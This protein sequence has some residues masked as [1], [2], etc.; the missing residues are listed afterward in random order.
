M[1]RKSNKR[2]EAPRR[3][4]VRYGRTGVMEAVVEA[5]SADEVSDE[6]LPGVFAGIPAGMIGTH[7][8]DVRDDEFTWDV[9]EAGEGDGAPTART[10]T[11]LG[12]GR[13]GKGSCLRDDTW[14]EHVEAESADGAAEE[15]LRRR[16]A[17]SGMDDSA[18]LAVFGGRHEDALADIA[19]RPARRGPDGRTAGRKGTR[20]ATCSA[21]GKPCDAR[22]AHLHR[23]KL[24]GDE[25][26]WDERLRASE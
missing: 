17:K 7:V 1:G 24:V 11:V 4:K 2:N 15:A 8:R 14:L 16:E 10:F 25:C 5:K 9:T 20:N 3:F 23:G 21:C 12:I 13:L 6:G 26:C 22:K 18:V 19:G